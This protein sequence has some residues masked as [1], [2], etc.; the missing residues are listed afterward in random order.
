[1]DFDHP[2][3]PRATA[4]QEAVERRSIASRAN[5]VKMARESLNALSGDDL[6][7]V[8]YTILVDHTGLSAEQLETLA[9]RLGRAA[10]ERAR[11]V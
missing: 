9:N 8:A 4:S 11:N 5:T 3:N 10:H 6:A 7:N 1:M 2:F